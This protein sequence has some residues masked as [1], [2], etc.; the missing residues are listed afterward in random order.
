[1]SIKVI[2]AKQNMKRQRT[3]HDSH[4][5]RVAAYCRVSTDLEEQESSYDAQIR[6][7]TA[8]VNEHPDLMLAGI[9]ADEGISGTGTMHREQFMRMIRDCENGR[10]DMVLTKSI[11]RFARNTLDCLQYIRKLKAMEIPIYFEKEAINTLDAKG[12]ILITIMASIA[13]QESQSI[14]QNVRMG[15]QYHFQQGKS[16]VPHNCFLGYGQ[17]EHG[18]LAIDAEEAITVRHIYRWFLDG[19]SPQHIAKLLEQSG[20]RTGRGGEKWYESTV[21]GILQNEKYMG[22]SIMQ[23]YYTVDFLTHKVKKNTGQLPQY[24]VENHHAPIVPKEVYMQ[25][26]GGLARRSRLKKESG[27]LHHYG[28]KRALQGRLVCGFCGAPLRRMVRANNRVVWQCT[29]QG[30]TALG[31][32]SDEQKVQAC[33]ISAI[34][35]LPEERDNL[36][37]LQE[38]ILW[39][40][41][42]RMDEK[43]EELEKK[44]REAEE[45]TAG[46]G[47]LGDHGGSKAQESEE[48]MQEKM[49][50]LRNERAEYAMQELYVRN[51]MELTDRIMGKGM[52]DE[53]YL[54]DYERENPSCSEYEDFFVRTRGEKGSGPVTEFED[55]RVIRYVEKISV[56]EGILSVD[57]KAGVRIEESMLQL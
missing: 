18:E 3:D 13:Q 4:K 44:I 10:I 55:M 52:V 15:I 11:S 54:A 5:I 36:I 31:V 8:Y 38:R 19:Y 22:D 9:Y 6:H 43:I 30:C 28:S 1:M 47:D 27:K 17:G 12:E 34:N 32:K 42:L 41:L 50:D 25:V 29:G 2:P 39:G 45:Q 7:Y 16:R 49:L 33:V 20:I 46:S 57:F 56:R 51:L 53:R 35:R 23:K 48:A 21:R 26:Q 37:R 24:Y 14:S 40:P